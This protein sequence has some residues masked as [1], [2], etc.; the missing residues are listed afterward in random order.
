MA[1]P[2]VAESGRFVILWHE[3]DNMPGRQNHYDFLLESAGFFI[4]IE[5][6]ALPWEVALVRGKVLSPHRLEYWDLEGPI[7]GNRG[8]VKRITRGNYQ[9]VPTEQNAWKLTLDSAEVQTVLSI[10]AEPTVGEAQLV[11]DTEV[12]ICAIS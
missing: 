1:G 8:C 11:P 9:M 3:V 7:S 10:R 5:L 12:R 6:S 4:T 2:N